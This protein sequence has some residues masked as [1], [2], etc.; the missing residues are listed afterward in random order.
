MEVVPAKASKTVRP[1]SPEEALGIVLRQLRA[2]QNLSQDELAYRS[3][4]HRN[5]IG[6]VERGEK[7]PSIRT[8]FNLA[9]ALSV[10]PSQILESTQ[11]ILARRK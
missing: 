2:A 3:G 1:S 6:H 5:Y 7:S 4:Y 8:L 9:D 11:M 10:K